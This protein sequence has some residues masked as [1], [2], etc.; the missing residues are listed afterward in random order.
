MKR[1]LLIL[2]T[3][4]SLVCLAQKPKSNSS[5]YLKKLNAELKITRDYIDKQ[6]DNRL[7]EFAEF[8]SLPSISSLP[9]HATDVEKAASWLVAKCNSMGFTKAMVAK[10]S[11]NPIVFAEWSKVKGKPT[12]LIYGHYDVQPV[13]EEEWTSPPFKATRKDNRIYAR[14]AA[15][16]K[17]GIM[18]AVWAV[19]A[20]LKNNNEKLP[21]NVKFLFEGSEEAGSVG[22]RKFLEENKEML[23]ADFA[24]NADGGQSSETE[25]EIGL[26]LR[27]VVPL[28]FTV[29]TSEKD[30]HSGLYG[31]KT[32]NAAKAMAEIISS[33]YQSDGKVAV[34]G[35]YDKVAPITDA[36]KEMINK[37]P[38]DAAKEMKQTG[39]TADVG[40][41]DYSP[42]E[43]VWFRPTLEVNGVWGG[44]TAKDG[45]STIIPG[46]AHARI[47]CRLVADQDAMEIIRL[48]KQHIAE[49]SP[50]GTE[51][52][53]KDFNSFA[54]PVKYPT[55]TKAFQSAY[56][57]LTEIYG[58][59]PRLTGDGGSI[60]AMGDI[61]D[62]LGLYAYSFGFVLPDENF[63]GVDEFIR[64]SDIRTGQFAYC[65]LLKY[66]GAR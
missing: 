43:R 56:D 17:G 41:P 44:Y 53:Y 13:K 22:L 26:G 64:L 28:E 55:D 45:F 39:T 35:F 52:T 31:G 62:M 8:L 61:K 18:I 66:L 6:Q 58:K 50:A 3:F 15:D 1:S 25:P 37:T 23:R 46:T 38:Y 30:L 48:I 47:S 65:L 4:L 5:A 9:D 63:H 40:D 60:A 42:L 34:N 14:G 32:P 20:L 29:K 10:S 24:Y 51:V 36:E 2:L 19:E 59:E 11:G 12:V 33:F 7:K 16:D 21:V 57:V 54:S 49:H 27:G